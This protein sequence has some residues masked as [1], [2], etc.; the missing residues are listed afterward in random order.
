M[1]W[2]GVF[3]YE[4]LGSNP[5]GADGLLVMVLYSTDLAEV[6]NLNQHVIIIL[7]HPKRGK[8]LQEKSDEN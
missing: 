5:K 4:Y 2:I 7:H 8:E 1:S 6:I 3:I